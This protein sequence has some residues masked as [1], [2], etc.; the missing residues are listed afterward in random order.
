MSTLNSTL[1]GLYQNEITNLPNLNDLRYENIFKVY[2]TD[3]NH[4]YYNIL[5]TVALPTDL[6]PNS[7]Y[8]INYNR[9]S[10]WTAIS[11][12]VYNT[13]DLWWLILLTN[14]IVNPIKISDNLTTLKIIKPEYVRAIVTEIQAQLQ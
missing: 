3:Q 9:R 2:K 13:T 7:Y 4:Y 10:P 1:S 14:Q 8:T 5:N 12:N 11:Y 6:H